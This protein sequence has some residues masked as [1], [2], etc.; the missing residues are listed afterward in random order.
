[1]NEHLSAL[2]LDEIVAG[3][4]PAPLHLAGCAECSQRVEALKKESAAFLARPEA[5]AQLERLS[6][7]PQRRSFLRVLA[8]AV[9]LAAGL[10]LFFAWPRPGVEDR[11]KGAPTIALLDEAGNAVTH[12]APGRKLTLAVGAAG[13]PR[14]TVTAVDASGKID[15]L[16][17]G[18]VAAG[19]RVPLMQLEVTPGDVTV[20]AVFERGAEK[21]AASVRLAVP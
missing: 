8:I 18:P 6:P 7:A 12:A 15:A 13:F 5:R 21:Q 3:L 9:P 19:A 11:I 4:N 1:M 10:A 14:V 20:T 16:Y 17:S 2:Q